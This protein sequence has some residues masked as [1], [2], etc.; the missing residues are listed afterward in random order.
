MEFDGFVD[1]RVAVTA[2]RDV[3][4]AD[5]RLE[6]PWNEA[7][8]TYMMGL[9]FKGGLR[10]LDLRV[11]LGPEKEPGRAL[12]RRR[13]R[14]D[15]GRPARRELLPAAQHEFLP[16]Q[17]ARH[18]AV[19]VERGPGPRDRGPAGPGTGKGGGKVP[20][21]VLTASSGPRSLRTGETLHFDFTL[22]I[23]PFKPIDPA[24]HFRDALL[25]RLQAARR[26]RGGGRQRRQRPPRQRRQPLHQLSVPAR[27]RR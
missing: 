27:R 16:V 18:A 14:R 23:T 19:V 12:A 26:G 6:V 9:G 8:A 17:A 2:R 10:R 5:I 22:L 25:P 11:D 1:Y 24:A 7:S 21:V 15:A 13:P 3:A 20:A 4:L